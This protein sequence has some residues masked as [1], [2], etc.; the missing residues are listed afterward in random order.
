[1]KKAGVGAVIAL[2]LA[3]NCVCADTK[4]MQWVKYG[5]KLYG[6]G[7]YEKAIIAYEKAIEINPDN[8]YAYMY[9]GYAYLQLKDTDT[10]DED[11]QRAYD[12]LPSPALKKQIDALDEKVFGE[13]KFMLYPITF[14]VM[15]G[16]GFD[17]ESFLKAAMTTGNPYGSILRY[18]GMA[19]YH[20]T[21]WFNLEGGLIGGDGVD[22]PVVARF[23][24]KLPWNNKTIMGLGIGGYFGMASSTAEASNG[25]YISVDYH[26]V[27]GPV[28]ILA[29]DVIEYGL[30]PA[31]S[32]LAE[33][34][35][36]GVAF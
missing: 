28:S 6:A 4:D 3:V 19:A 24:Y 32:R 25:L 30:A 9:M 1:M 12:I 10:A 16:F 26:Y 23:S 34:G 5:N 22:I 29:D 31:E 14:K 2:M 27:I 20:F 36:L 33:M 8:S 13:G 21:D 15:I 11:F 35:F 18:S 7:Q 17:L